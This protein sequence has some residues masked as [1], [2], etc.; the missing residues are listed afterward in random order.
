MLGDSTEAQ[1]MSVCESVCPHVCE[2]MH[3]AM[4]AC[5]CVLVCTHVSVWLYG[6]MCACARVY[7][8]ACVL[9]R[10]EGLENWVLTLSQC[11]G[12]LCELTE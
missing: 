1:S 3:V 9:V 12:T 8:R 6:H 5:V 11:E 10:Q 7:L 4:N 2:H